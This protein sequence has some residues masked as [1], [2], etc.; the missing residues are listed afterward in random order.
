MAKTES[1]SK[2]V[3]KCRTCGE[4][5]AAKLR[6]DG[7]LRPIGVADCTCGNGDLRRLSV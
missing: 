2:F 1:E 5:F 4:V 7:S 6:R 3:A